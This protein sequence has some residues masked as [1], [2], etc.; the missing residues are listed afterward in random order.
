MPLPPP[1]APRPRGRHLLLYDGPCGLCN[2][3]VAFLLP[4]DVAAVFAF[5]PLQSA[6]GQSWLRRFGRATDDLRTFHVVTNY[7]SESPS[8]LSKSRAALFVTTSLGGPWRAFRVFRLLPPRT[9]DRLYD[10][11]ARNRHRLFGRHGTCPLPAPEYR[12]RFIDL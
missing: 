3:L 5:A 6:T 11:V 1:Q 4:R 7:R 9:L 8:L 10:A 2:R 12:P